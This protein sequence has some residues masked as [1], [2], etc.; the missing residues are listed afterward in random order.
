MSS[1]PM[2]WQSPSSLW[3]GHPVLLHPS[4]LSHTPVSRQQ[5]AVCIWQMTAGSGRTVESFVMVF[6][7]CGMQ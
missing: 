1:Q 2:N 3:A 4:P 6:H 5:T 7:R